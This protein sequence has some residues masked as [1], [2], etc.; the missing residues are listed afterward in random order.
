[1]FDKLTQEQKRGWQ[2]ELQQHNAGIT[3]AN[4]RLNEP[5]SILPEGVEPQEPAPLLT[6]DEFLLLRLR[7]IGDGA[8]A[9][10]I[11]IKEQQAIE[12]FRSLTPEQQA[13]LVAQF[14]IPDVLK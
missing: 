14:Q 11:R 2:Y 8:Y 3:A 7:Q 12:M 13:A 5:N 4:E 9:T 6:M 10:I 1:M